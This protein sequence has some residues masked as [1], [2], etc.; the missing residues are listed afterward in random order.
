MEALQNV[1]TTLNGSVVSHKKT[2]VQFVCWTDVQDVMVG[3]SSV[4]VT[5]NF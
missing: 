5:N 1:G 2:S 4:I 3:N